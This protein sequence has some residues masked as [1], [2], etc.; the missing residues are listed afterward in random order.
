MRTTRPVEDLCPECIKI[1][2][3]RKKK[4]NSKLEKDPRRYFP[5]KNLGMA[6]RPGKDAPEHSPWGKRQ[7]NHSKKPQHP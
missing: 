1:P 5:K 3:S 4:K 2:Q 6:S 7:V